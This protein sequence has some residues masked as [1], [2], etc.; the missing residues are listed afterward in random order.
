M[1]LLFNI[2]FSNITEAIFTA[3]NILMVE[4]VHFNV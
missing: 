3:V 1:L 2:K 4:K